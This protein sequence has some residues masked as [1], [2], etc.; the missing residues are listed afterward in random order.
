MRVSICLRIASHPP[1]GM[2]AI[3]TTS[4][5]LRATE[6]SPDNN[7][8]LK[9]LF[10]TDGSQQGQHTKDVGEPGTRTRLGRH[11]DR[12]TRCASSRVVRGRKAD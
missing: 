6:A 1:H 8:N 7:S 11:I 12:T 2:Q 5:A 4:L 3:S 9:W 10:C